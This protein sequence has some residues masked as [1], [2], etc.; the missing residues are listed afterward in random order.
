MN[1]GVDIDSI[2]RRTREC[3][4]WEISKRSESQSI[5]I[6]SPTLG[7]STGGTANVNQPGK[8]WTLLCEC[9]I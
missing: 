9:S 8:Q 1:H 7:A 4:A 6:K 2:V 3:R 5:R